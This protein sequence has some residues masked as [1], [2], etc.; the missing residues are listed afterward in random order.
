[1][2]AKSKKVVLFFPSYASKEAAPPL[3]LISIAA[4]LLQAGYSVRIIDSTLEKDYL[5]AVLSEMEDALCLGISIITGPMIREAVAVGRAV[6]QKHPQIPVLLG[7]WHPSILPEQTLR[8][9]SVDVVVLKQGEETL[10]DLVRC[11]EAGES[12]QNL[13]GILWKDGQEV[14]RNPARS[15]PKVAQLPSRLPGYD[16]IDYDRYERMTGLRWVMY[17]SSHGCPYNCSYCS[18]AS[19]YGRNLDV[20]PVEQVVDEVG[21]LV[22]KHGIRLL[23]II[24]DIYFAFMDRCLQMAEGFLQAGLKFEWYIQDRVDCWARLRPEQARLYR[25]AGLVRIHFGAESGSD[26]VLRSIE[27]RADIDKTVQALERCR[28][29][30]IRAS[31][32]FIFGFPDEQEEDLQA[33]L[34]LIDRIY[35]THPRADCYTNIFTPYPGSPL[36]PVALEKGF[37]APDDLE[38]WA[39]FY[40]RITRLPWL[41]EAQHRRLQAIRQSLRFGYHQVNVGEKP[42]PL[43]HRLLM[44]LLK[45]VSRYRIRRKSFDR[46]WEI[47][48]YWG[49]QKL[50]RSLSVQERF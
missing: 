25:R 35:A 45:P 43:R 37:Q 31:F 11:F 20:L 49:L 3:A 23:G 5:K 26:K 18:N 39:D 4:P 33:T 27:K 17:S 7:G 16:L 24:D 19:V 8:E 41:S 6:K 14:I 15:H 46:P 48:G 42:Y 47:Y 29:A 34:N 22:R 28:E 13:S 40:P 21:W 30:D 1:M 38:G 2:M 32:G 12:L 10:L 50:W 36:W 9:P 44:K